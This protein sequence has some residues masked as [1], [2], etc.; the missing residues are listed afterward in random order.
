MR[1]LIIVITVLIIMAVFF[2]YFSQN[3]LESKSVSLAGWRSSEYGYQQEQGPDYWIDVANQMT[4]NFTNYNPAGIWILGVEENGSCYLQFPNDDNFDY[5]IFSEEDINENYLDAFDNANLSIWLQV[6]PA[7]ANVETLIDLV[8]SRYM[9]HPSV[10]GFG[11]DVEWLENEE[12]SK[13]R[14]VTS[15]EAESWLDKIKS[16]NPEYKLF[17]KH[18]DIDK[19][20]KSYPDDI[21]F[22]SDSQDFDS[23]EEM[24]EEF[25]EWGEHFS[26]AEVGFQY[27]YESDRHIWDYYDDP[28][29]HIGNDLIDNVPNCRGLYWV[30][31]TITDVFQP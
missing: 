21:V 14:P 26:D 24:M 22:I 2:L 10:I 15:M 12:F 7:N 13:G 11:V 30:D 18:W 31:F 28:A 3:N 8:L 29:D 20:P 16:Y 17:L 23:Y 4:S 1:K 9:H 27:G 19:M 5:I 25:K 6:E